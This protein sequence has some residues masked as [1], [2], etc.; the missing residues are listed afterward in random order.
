MGTKLTLVKLLDLFRRLLHELDIGSLP[1][2]ALTNL[3]FETVEQYHSFWGVR[4]RSLVQ[5]IVYTIVECPGDSLALANA[6]TDITARL[7][8]DYLKVG[9]RSTMLLYELPLDEAHADRNPSMRRLVPKTFDT[10]STQTE[11][12]I[13]D[14]SVRALLLD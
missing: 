9:G 14:Q 6:R 12:T 5:H 13:L 7:E 10:K 8:K 2:M 1:F 3:M 11:G 4:T